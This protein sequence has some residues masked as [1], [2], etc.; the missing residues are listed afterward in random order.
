M[1][2]SHYIH[3]SLNEIDANVNEKHFD[4]NYNTIGNYV[5]C[6]PVANLG[7]SPVTSPQNEGGL[8]MESVTIFFFF[9]RFE[10]NY[11][12]IGI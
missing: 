5:S 12:P 8:D 10:Y 1:R 2:S 11:D 6:P 7:L 9:F 4:L 3:I